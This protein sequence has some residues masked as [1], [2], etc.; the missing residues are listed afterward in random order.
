MSKAADQA[1]DY[2]RKAIVAGELAPGSSLREENL[3]HVVGVSRTPVRDALRRLE[4]EQL[5]RRTESKRSYVADWSLDD[6]EEGFKLR[7]ML[8]CHAASR[9]A[10]NIQSNALTNLERINDDIGRAVRGDIPDPEAFTS[11]NRS[12]HS[13]IIDAAMSERLARLL[14]GLVAQPVVLRTA[15]RY[16]RAQ[17]EQSVHEHSE[18]IKAFQRRDSSWAE[19]IMAAHIRRAYHAYS[20]AFRDYLDG[21]AKGAIQS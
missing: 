7:S 20:D 21:V 3:A 4:S 9:A 11:L 5:V 12:F 15:A 13:I 18:L 19:S 14:T 16:D 8:E 10:K 6:V 2:I 17:L 1:Y